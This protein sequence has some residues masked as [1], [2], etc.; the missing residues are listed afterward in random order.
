MKRFFKD[1]RRNGDAYKTWE[2]GRYSIL[3]RWD[4]YQNDFYLGLRYS[5]AYRKGEFYILGICFWYLRI[6]LCAK[7]ETRAGK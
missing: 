4:E 3:L 1:I 5:P 2:F 6:S 7:W